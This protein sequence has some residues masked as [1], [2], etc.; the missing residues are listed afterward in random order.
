MSHERGSTTPTLLTPLHA[1]KT[2]PSGR[3]HAA[4]DAATGRDRG[5]CELVTARIEPDDGVRLDA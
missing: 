5:P 2:R 4:D 1:M 3:R